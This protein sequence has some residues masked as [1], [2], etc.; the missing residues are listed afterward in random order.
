[1]CRG[2]TMPPQDHTFTGSKLDWVQLADGLPQ[3]R[4]SRSEG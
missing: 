1:M 3:Y 2:T 4:R